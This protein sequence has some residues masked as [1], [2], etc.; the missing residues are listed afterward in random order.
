VLLR[1]LTQLPADEQEHWQ[2]FE[3]TQQEQDFLPDSVDEPFTKWYYGSVRT[4]PPW[5]I[6]TSEEEDD[7]DD[8]N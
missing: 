4:K 3:L 1:Y 5:Q 6:E 7:D 8:E 2:S